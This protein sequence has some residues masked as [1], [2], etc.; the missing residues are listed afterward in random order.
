MSTILYD[1]YILS[2]ENEQENIP[3]LHNTNNNEEN[4]SNNDSQSRNIINKMDTMNKISKTLNCKFIMTFMMSI[5]TFSILIIGYLDL[6]G[7][8]KDDILYTN[9]G[10]LLFTYYYIINIFWYITFLLLSTYLIL[11]MICCKH[12][13]VIKGTSYFNFLRL[14]LIIFCINIVCKFIYGAMILILTFTYKIDNT[15]NTNYNIIPK[16]Y[17]LIIIEI[18][19]Y[20]MMLFVILQMLNNI[21]DY[22]NLSK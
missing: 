7:V 17:N 15:Y 3:L 11:Y 14:N 13:E 10:E 4:S 16:Y 9:Y 2:E 8:N 5:L 12:Y 1:N 21:N 19:L 18:L 6:K 22:Y 20:F